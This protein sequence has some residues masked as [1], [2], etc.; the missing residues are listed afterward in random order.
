MH[1]PFDA[2][3]YVTGMWF[4]SLTLLFNHHWSKQIITT[5]QLSWLFNADN[6]PPQLKG[7]S[8]ACQDSECATLFL[9]TELNYICSI[10]HHFCVFAKTHEKQII[11]TQSR[12]INIL[13][14]ERSV[15][16]ITRIHPKINV[17]SIHPPKELVHY[18]SQ[19]ICVLVHV[20]VCV[21]VC[22]HASVLFPGSLTFC[23]NN[24]HCWPI[25]V[26]LFCSFPFFLCFA[27]PPP[28]PFTHTS[29]SPVLFFLTSLGNTFDLC[30]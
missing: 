25:T 9:Q 12:L 19:N 15:A 6:L 5:Q 26:W 10:P 17:Y 18:T 23:K 28:P 7:S 30:C 2:M 8:R 29:S 14:S 1:Q 27:S 16:A 4:C 3:Y 24:F 21:C 13:L 20:C 22:A 11:K